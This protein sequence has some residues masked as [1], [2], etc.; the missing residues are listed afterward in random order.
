MKT[1]IILK[2][3]LISLFVFS[4]V[5]AA[6]L[7]TADK[8][9]V[10]AQLEELITETKDSKGIIQM[11]KFNAEAF[12]SLE[13]FHVD[14]KITRK[15][16]LVFKEELERVRVKVSDKDK[17]AQ[18]RK[19]FT[20][21]L[22]Q[23]DKTSKPLVKENGV[24][25]HWDCEK[26]LECAP[27]P[28]RAEKR[29]RSKGGDQFCNEN[30]E[31][32]SGECYKREEDGKKVCDYTYRCFRPLKIGSSCLSNPV[33]GGG[34]CKEV[35]Y[36]DGNIGA[37]GKAETSCK[38][39]VDC[40]S[41]SCVKGQCVENYKC[42]DCISSG[43]LKRGQKCCVDKAFEKNGSCVPIVVPLNPFVNIFKSILDIVIPTASA[44]APLE[45][46]DGG[47]GGGGGGY[48][49]P[50]T[51]NVNQ[52]YRNNVGS[53][54][55]TGGEG[56]DAEQL[57]FRG[58]KDIERFSLATDKISNFET[59]E[60][61]L[62][63]DYA[64]RMSET[65]MPGNDQVTMLQVEL[66]LLGFE[67][68]AGG[69]NQIKDYWKGG[70]ESQ[71]LHERMRL[72]A[73]KRAKVRKDFYNDVKW[74]E[75]KVECL[76]LEKTGWKQMTA[77]QK[78]IYE[79]KCRV[80]LAIPPF[81]GDQNPDTLQKYR[82][83]RDAKS[84]ELAASPQEWSEKIA[85]YKR[86]EENN[87]IEEGDD[88]LGIKAL[89]L[90]I[91]WANANATIEEMSIIA[92]GMA[93]E[94]L[95]VIEKW[96]ETEAK[97]SEVEER[98][99][100]LYMFTVDE[101]P[102]P[103]NPMLV[104]AL[105]SAG[106]IAIMGGFAFSATISAWATIGVVTSA[107]AS[108]GAGMWMIG[109]LR[110]A[111]YS[112]SPYVSDQNV[113]SYKCGKNDG[114]MCYKFQRTLTQPYN[115]V[116]NKHISASACI[117]HFLVVEEN[118]QQ[119]MLVDPWIP[120]G[121]GLNE[122]VKD[123]RPLADLLESGYN[124]AYSLMRSRIPAPH[125][126]KYA[127]E[128][129]ANNK[130][131]LEQTVITNEVLG[132]YAPA[133]RSNAQ[134][135]ILNPAVKETIIAKAAEFLVDQGWAT[136]PMQAKKFGEYVYK[137]HFVWS[138]MTY[139]D[140]LAYPQPGLVSYIGLIANALATSMEM[141]GYNGGGF[142]ERERLWKKYKKD[143]E[144]R[145]VPKGD[146]I[147]IDGRPN[148][149]SGT[150]L[151]GDGTGA[152]GIGFNNLD[153]LSGFG[154][155]NMAGLNGKSGTLSGGG[156]GNGGF[157]SSLFSS[158]VNSALSNLRDYR[159]EQK[160]KADAFKDR[161]GGTDRGK[162]LLE[163]AGNFRDE[164][165]AN[166]TNGKAAGSGGLGLGSAGNL[167]GS[168]KDAT[169]LGNSS[170]DGK[171]GDKKSSFFGEGIGRSGN[172]GAGAGSGQGAGFGSGDYGNGGGGAYGDGSG[173][174]ADGRGAG[175]LSPEDARKLSDAIKSRDGNGGKYSRKDGMTLWEIVTNTYIRVYDR[176][177]ERRSN[178]LD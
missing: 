165:Y 56:M 61:N 41:D 50:P 171:D 141:S 107:A 65:K 145:F 54:N 37:C 178:D 76:C 97:W 176:L 123:T 109:S 25:N 46:I 23:V 79:N 22:L 84:L 7:S 149:G 164:F 5:Q 151:N 130:S 86:A 128:G 88:A 69:D 44:L 68:V 117:K 110:G 155:G 116:C 153:S 78:E 90:L 108:I 138:K 169:N 21:N 154:S 140:V 49:P 175:G 29:N 91:A 6:R 177:L 100:S 48:V 87:E 17:E 167:L 173:D 148:N 57:N 45:E 4:N 94:D 114:D 95:Q 58:Q 80:G 12:Q 159:K 89:E 1:S 139:S 156:F 39:N 137:N 112:A 129:V 75:P 105:L 10:E 152:N 104:V 53:S 120:Q 82:S 42:E 122:I 63:N 172:S 67:F 144:D 11:D 66:A 146:R 36:S 64:K 131:V 174:S 119:N 71:T 31:C 26:G 111:W 106:V 16:L 28:P 99:K 38:S 73:K 157:D 19:L 133:L 113:E 13:K 121:M 20:Q 147:S 81:E 101:A 124:S 158:G 115:D 35:Y 134:D 14:R 30:S 60:I 2:A 163:K 74:F 142:K 166:S 18:I 33:C 70:Q 161:V 135:Y 77:E 8:K 126:N 125:N 15:E 96:G 40:C 9:D 24:C 52:Q 43:K 118:G 162:R 136:D 32:T 102:A 72:I 92:S 3:L 127:R 98:K 103:S 55:S 51:S 143:I 85:E 150:T 93:M 59:C 62:L 168:N 34:E 83:E 170:G 132:K 27:V 160:A 47:G